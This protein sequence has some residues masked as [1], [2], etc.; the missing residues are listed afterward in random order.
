MLSVYAIRFEDKFHTG[1]KGGIGVGGQV[2]AQ[3]IVH[4]AAPLGGP[5]VAA[6]C[7]WQLHH[8]HGSYLG[9]NQ[10]SCHVHNTLCCRK[11]LAALI[12]GRRVTTKP[13]L[14][15]G[16]WTGLWTGLDYGLTH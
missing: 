9:C 15:T 12:G 11:G 14:W 3:G 16:P 6:M 2:S 10:G 4:M 13:G 1:I 8:A 7:T 5:K